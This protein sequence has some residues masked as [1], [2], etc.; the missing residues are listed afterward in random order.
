MAWAERSQDKTPSLRHSRKGHTE[1][2]GPPSPPRSQTSR[3]DRVSSPAGEGINAGVWDASV[4]LPF[5]PSCSST[6]GEEGE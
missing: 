1:V 5:Y 6:V 4:T 3:L 2:P